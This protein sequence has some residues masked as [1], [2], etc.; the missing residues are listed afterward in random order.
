MLEIKKL[1]NCMKEWALSLSKEI[2]HLSYQRNLSREK[3][4]VVEAQSYEDINSLCSEDMEYAEDAA[5]SNFLD[6]SESVLVA[7]SDYIDKLSFL[8]DQKRN[9]TK[10]R[11]LNIN[12]KLTIEQ[13]KILERVFDLIQQE[14]DSTESEKFIN[15]IARQF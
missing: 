6:R 14:Y 11:A 10:Y 8:I 12:P 4:A 15:L 2:R 13:R 3:K 1:V 5:E 9:H 7:E